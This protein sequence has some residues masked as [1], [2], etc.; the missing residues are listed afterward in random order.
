MALDHLW[1]TWRSDYVRS[2][3]AEPADG[4]GGAGGSGSGAGPSGS[5][6]ER[7]LASGEPDDRTLIVRRGPTCFVLLNRF[8]YTSGHLMVLPNRAVADLAALTDEEHSELWSTVTSA[9]TALRSAVDCDAVN[10]GLN[11]GRAAGGSQSDH[12][13]VHCVPRWE[14]DANFMTVAA[15][16]RVL[17]VSLDE[18]WSR[19]REAWPA[20]DA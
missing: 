16:T 15:G 12:L 20:A 5:L 6:F 19:L 10:V 8:P 4:S 11:L 1:A 14:G 13:H 2:V 17:P 9:V 3:G 18:S 7:I